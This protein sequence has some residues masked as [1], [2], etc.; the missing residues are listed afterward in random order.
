MLTGSQ[1]KAQAK[2]DAES[3]KQIHLKLSRR[4]DADVVKALDSAESR[5]GYTKRPMRADISR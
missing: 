3:T 2:H 5:Q 4:T 1:K